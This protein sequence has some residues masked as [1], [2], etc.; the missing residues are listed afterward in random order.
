MASFN[1]LSKPIREVL[2][3]TGWWYQ[4]IPNDLLFDVSRMRTINLAR[5]VSMYL[6]REDLKMT[7]VEIGEIF[8]K[9]HAAVISALKR[10]QTLL[11]SGDKERLLKEIA[12]IRHRINTNKS[13]K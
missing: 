5:Q 9:N 4:V 13:T 3:A 10:I 7:L 11:S 1:H 6:M 2:D 8:G 12:G